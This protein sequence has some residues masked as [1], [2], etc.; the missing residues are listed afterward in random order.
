MSWTSYDKLIF[1]G[2]A[3]RDAEMKYTPQGTA[4]TK[5]S[6][7][8]DRSYKDKTGEQ[9]KKTI[10]YNVVFWGKVAEVAASVSK[11]DNV[12]IEGTLETDETGSPRVWT[13]KDGTAKASF[14]VKAYEIKFL[15]P[16]KEKEQVHPDDE[17]E[18]FV[19]P[20]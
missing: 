16:R 2:R 8:V 7:A 20:F 18:L 9:V 11:G 4:V 10:W 3:G 6:V 1:V 17:E 15:S 19:E 14:E 5:F 12:L 13:A